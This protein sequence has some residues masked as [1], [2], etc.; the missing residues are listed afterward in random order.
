MDNIR[1]FCDNLMAWLCANPLPTIYHAELWRPLWFKN[2]S[3][4]SLEISLLEKGNVQDLRIGERVVN[5][6]QGTVSIH[7]LHFGNYSPHTEARGRIWC[8]IIDASAMHEAFPALAADAFFLTDAPDNVAE[9][10]LV[11]GRLQQAHLR[12]RCAEMLNPK[13]AA[14][15]QPLQWLIKGL[16]LEL[17][18]LLA[19][20]TTA[21]AAR[22][23]SAITAALRLMEQEYADPGLTLEELA[24]AAC[25]SKAQF[26]RIFTEHLGISPMLFVQQLRLREAASLLRQTGHRISEIARQVGYDDAL[27]FSRLFRRAYGTSPRRYRTGALNSTE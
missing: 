26:G 24:A 19:E 18:A 25:L 17:L 11:F 21:A 1:V 6:P 12:Q 9:L 8:I 23:P 3:A 14:P 15:G 22:R 2:I 4:P 5:L 7:N 13:A 27:Y 20:G 16:L 10:C